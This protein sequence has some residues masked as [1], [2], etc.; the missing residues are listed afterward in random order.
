M[1]AARRRVW[2]ASHFR[3]DSGD[4]CADRTGGTMTHAALTPLLGRAFDPF[5]FAPIDED[6]RGRCSASS[7]RWRGSMSIRG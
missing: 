4:G 7:P 3:L 6:G 2:W 1:M 5:L